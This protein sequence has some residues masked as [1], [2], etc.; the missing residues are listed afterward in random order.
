MSSDS[1]SYDS[2]KLEQALRDL[3]PAPLGEDF[4]GR[5]EGAAEGTLAVLSAEEIRHEKALRAHRPLALPADFLA[6]LEGV[7]AD[8]PFV[9]DEKIVL[10]TKA[11]KTAPVAARRAQARPMWAAAAA[12]ALIGAATALFIPGRQAV[13][14]TVAARPVVLDQAAGPISADP[15]F[16]AAGFTRGLGEVAD[17]GVAWDG[18]AGQPHRVVRVKYLDRVTLKD[19]DGRTYEVEQPRFEYILIP[20]KVD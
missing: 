4:L 6:C 17:Q 19:K 15:N 14:G 13:T 9:K 1:T 10:F 5:L 3:G 2:K 7:V 8:V 16:R 11:A 12:V 20:E 18:G